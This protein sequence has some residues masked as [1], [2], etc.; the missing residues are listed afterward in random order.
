MMSRHAARL[1]C[2]LG[3]ALF[4]TIPRVSQAQDDATIEMARQ[5]FR[6]GVQYYD[7]HQFEKARLAFLQAY[8]LKP[9]PSVLLNLAQSE[10]RSGHPDDAAQHFAQYLRINASA[11]DAEKQETTIGYN[12]AKSRVGEVALAVD[13]TGATVLVDGVEKGV[14]P[15]TDPLYLLPGSHTIE[16]RASDRHVSKTVSLGA[17]QSVSVQLVVHGSM[18]AAGAPAPVETPTSE[19]EPTSEAATAAAA[20]EPPPEKTTLAED[21]TPPVTEGDQGG[22]QGLVDWFVSTPPAWILAGVGVVGL[23]VGATMGLVANHDYGNANNIEQGILDEWRTPRGNPKT[24]VDKDQFS[25]DT[26]P[27]SLPT[28]GTYD[29]EKILGNRFANYQDACAL[30]KSRA[31]SADTERTVAIV[32]TVVGGAA[33]IG[34]VVY[35][36]V[37][38]GPAKKAAARRLE[39][40][41]AFQA[42][43]TPLTGSGTAGVAVFGTF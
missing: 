18:A 1:F 39:P 37:D 14:A 20:S 16:A 24:F 21:T 38:R 4:L 6:E 13:P 41:P 15:L 32:S 2:A 30:Y 31:N 3:V 9:H 27:C 33:L 28:G 10:L 7:Q 23:G 22:K 25:A 34:T 26:K 43:V 35:Y 42:H 8:A 12:T 11:S 19:G 17:G 40:A 29:A 5:R 36:F